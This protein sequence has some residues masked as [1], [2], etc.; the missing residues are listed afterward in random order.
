ML[1][2]GKPIQLNTARPMETIGDDF[3]NRIIGN[4]GMMQEKMTSTELLHF[5]ASPPEVYMGE[6]GMAPLVM[7]SSTSYSQ[8]FNIDMIN[9]V[10]NR[11]VLSENNHLTYQDRVYIENVL[12]KVGITNVSEFMRQVRM[13]QEETK[14][15]KQLLQLYMQ[16]QDSLELVKEY[17]SA[18]GSK[19]NDKSTDQLTE[20]DR[21]QILLDMSQQ[22]TNR[23]HTE[24]IYQEIAHRVTDY[25]MTTNHISNVELQLSEQSINADYMT[26]NR[27]RQ[28]TFNQNNNLVYSRVN[29]YEA[30]DVTEQEETY[31][32]TVTN[33][34]QAL[35]LSAVSQVFHNRYDE[36]I[37]KNVN[38]HNLTDTLHVL[39]ENTFK[40]YETYHNR[41]N[42][43]EIE[44]NEYYRSLQNIQHNEIN[45]LQRLI[46][47]TN[48]FNRV[49]NINNQTQVEENLDY[50]IEPTYVTSQEVTEEIEESLKQ[51]TDQHKH[52]YNISKQQETQALINQLNII[53]QQ[54]IERVQ[55]LKS[56]EANRPEE[57]PKKPNMQQARADG[58]RAITEGTDLAMEYLTRENNTTI[59]RQ[60]YTESL[61]EIIGQDT[62]NILQ[63]MEGYKPTAGQGQ[64]RI[65]TEGA[66]M[67]LLVQDASAVS[68]Q[69]GNSPSQEAALDNTKVL[70]ETSKEVEQVLKETERIRQVEM[71]AAQRRIET[72]RRQVELFH[73]QNE[74]AITEE[75]LEELQSKNSRTVE[76]RTIENTEQVIETHKVDEIINNRVNELKLQQNQEVEQLITNNVRQQLGILSDQVYNKLEKR[77]DSERRR[78]GM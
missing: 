54:N 24:E 53:N 6:G 74:T 61:K 9:N 48:N 19:A 34:I 20:T 70:R 45:T 1:T 38:W 29:A 23:L 47:N 8:D 25:A 10:L 26:L 17:L 44:R 39:S 59:E 37:Q 33:M 55:R 75:L 50:R 71:P 41:T 63:M 35:L 3:A 72:N 31:N 16:G 36:L 76:S 4:Y 62:V 11:I 67:D 46:E 77:I 65:V 57:E 15:T 32:E 14:N 56:F 58:L 51:Q 7:N 12:N 64:P 30:G 78:R 73:K 66:A 13:T 2:M 68:Q 49:E 5:I 21:E 60:Q 27:M 52:V 40:R 18:A 43:T 69:N 42:L 22:I 28:E